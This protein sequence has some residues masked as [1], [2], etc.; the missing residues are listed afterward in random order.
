MGL[1]EGE[2]GGEW[3]GGEEGEAEGRRWE[4]RGSVG[5]GYSPSTDDSMIGGLGFSNRVRDDLIA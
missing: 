3:E 5:G 4:E 1:L 2:E